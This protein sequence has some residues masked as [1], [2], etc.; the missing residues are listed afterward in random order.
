MLCSISDPL[1]WAQHLSSLRTMNTKASFIAGLSNL[2]GCETNSSYAWTAG[3]H[4]LEANWSPHIGLWHLHT[5]PSMQRIAIA[6]EAVHISTEATQLIEQGVVYIWL[7]CSVSIILSTVY[8]KIHLDIIHPCLLLLTSTGDVFHYGINNDLYT[9]CVYLSKYGTIM[10]CNV[11]IVHC[12]NVIFNNW[13]LIA[14]TLS[15]FLH[16]SVLL[17]V[18]NFQC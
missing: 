5:V 17:W 9:L 1:A 4:V 7:R 12:Y 13:D 16:F 3:L 2:S 8:V 15:S 18:H 11:L 14:N 6:K 10:L